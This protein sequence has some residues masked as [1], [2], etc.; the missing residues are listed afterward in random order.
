VVMQKKIEILLKKGW[1]TLNDFHYSK[2]I[3]QL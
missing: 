2:S 3:Q 1:V